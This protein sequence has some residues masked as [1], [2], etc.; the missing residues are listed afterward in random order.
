MYVLNYVDTHSQLQYLKWEKDKYNIT[1][2]YVHRIL[3]HKTFFFLIAIN[4]FL[5]NFFF[6]FSGSYKVLNKARNIQDKFENYSSTT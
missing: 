6:L 5:V 4:I 2:C 3:E 1:L